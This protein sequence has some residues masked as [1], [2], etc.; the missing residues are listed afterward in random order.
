[1]KLI[2][3]F[4]ANCRHDDLDKQYVNTLDQLQLFLIA[5]AENPALSAAVSYLAATWQN[6]RHKFELSA[7]L[8]LASTR[9]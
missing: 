2:T 1:M 7:E 3:E 4:I 8:M 9:L 6:F 5:H